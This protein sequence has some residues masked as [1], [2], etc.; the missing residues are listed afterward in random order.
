MHPIDGSSSTYNTPRSFDPNLRRQP[1]A[2]SLAAR[3]RSRQRL[4]KCIPADG[5]QKLQSLYDFVRHPPGDHFLPPGQLDLLC[6]FEACSTG[7]AVKS[8]IDIAFT[9]TARLRAAALPLTNS[10]S[11]RRHVIHQPVAVA[12]D[13]D[14]SRFCLRYPKIP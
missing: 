1:D 7:M 8:A 10:T 12:F 13:V 2:L 3:Q 6:D 4:A 5:V 11:R 9:F 14:S